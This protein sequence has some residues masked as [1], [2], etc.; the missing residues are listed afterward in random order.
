MANKRL[1]MIFKN[2]KGKTSKLSLDNPREDITGEDIRNAMENIVSANVFNTS[3]GDLVEAV[4]ARIVNTD[5]E[6][7][8]LY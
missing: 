3:D 5:I 1:E 8:A 7:I 4:S 2:Q 6:E